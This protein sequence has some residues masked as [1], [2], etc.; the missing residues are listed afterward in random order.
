MPIICCLFE[1]S[2][3]KWTREKK[4]MFERLSSKI[5]EVYTKIM[6]S[7][8]VVQKEHCMLVC[9]KLSIVFKQNQSYFA[10]LVMR[11][12]FLR[13]TRKPCIGAMEVFDVIKIDESLTFQVK[14]QSHVDYPR[15]ERD[16]P[17]RLLLIATDD[18]STNI[19]GAPAG[20]AS[21]S[22]WK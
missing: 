12:G 2:Q 5:W 16:H 10:S 22:E 14:S 19:P 1:W 15:C 18:Q 4:A 17:Q 21:P 11:H 13:T 3:V 9:Q 6:P 8:S 20:S 7:L